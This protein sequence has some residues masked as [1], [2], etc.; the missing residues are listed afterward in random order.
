MKLRSKINGLQLVSKGY[1]QVPHQKHLLTIKA[2]LAY[3]RE[4][5][6]VDPLE[7][8]IMDK[9]PSICKS[10]DL[11]QSHLK[12]SNNTWRIQYTLCIENLHRKLLLL[13]NS[14][15]TSIFR[16]KQAWSFVMQ[17]KV[18]TRSRTI[19]ILLSIILYSNYRNKRLRFNKQSHLGWLQQKKWVL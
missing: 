16:T 17:N 1:C 4:A 5:Q 19:K 13:R 3:S 8:L 14:Q 15:W 7:L 6:P 11:N 18:L 10:M 9:F 12:M 2:K